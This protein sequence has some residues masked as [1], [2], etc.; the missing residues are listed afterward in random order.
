MPV[1]ICGSRRVRR[2]LPFCVCARLPSS[3]RRAGWAGQL[4]RPIRKGLAAQVSPAWVRRTVSTRFRVPGKPLPR[5]SPQFPPA[6]PSPTPSPSD[7]NFF[8]SPTM[9]PW[10]E[11]CRE[12]NVEQPAVGRVGMGR[13]DKG[14]RREASPTSSLIGPTPGAPCL[15]PCVQ[16]GLQVAGE[17]TGGKA[18]YLWPLEGTRARLLVHSLSKCIPRSSYPKPAQY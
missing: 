13:S 16:A 12:G 11:G 15:L 6:T 5:V 8:P 9:E 14:D 10:D 2:G 4:K 1:D 18:G 17:W 7:L 3:I